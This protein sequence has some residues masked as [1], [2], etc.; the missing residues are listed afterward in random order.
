MGNVGSRA[1]RGG[2]SYVTSITLGRFKNVTAG[3]LMQAIRQNPSRFPIP[4]DQNFTLNATV[5]LTYWWTKNPVKVKKIIEEDN[6]A[7]MELEAAPNHTF[8]G[9]AIHK[10]SRDVDT[11]V[12]TYEIEGEGTPQEKGYFAALNNIFGEKVWPGLVRKT[13]PDIARGLSKR[14]AK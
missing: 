8:I 7:S 5:N 1:V 6:F 13:I 4:G 2:H 9:K 12:L 3:A 11:D 14:E 10:I